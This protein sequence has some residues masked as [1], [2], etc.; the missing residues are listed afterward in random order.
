[1]LTAVPLLSLVGCAI[2]SGLCLLLDGWARRRVTCCLCRGW[3]DEHLPGQ[4]HHNR[5]VSWGRPS[6]LSW[7]GDG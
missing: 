2:M 3:R 7:G 4:L 1:M 5:S 6:R